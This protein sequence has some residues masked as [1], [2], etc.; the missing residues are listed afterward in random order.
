MRYTVLAIVAL[1]VAG[2]VA[3]P[4]TMHK[5]MPPPPAATM[6]PVCPHGVREEWCR[7]LMANE[8]GI[9]N[10]GNQPNEE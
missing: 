7:P 10:L 1:A 4:P 8:K 2:C 9:T 5:T 6:K 3:Q